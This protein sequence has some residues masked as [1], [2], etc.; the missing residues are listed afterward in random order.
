MVRLEHTIIVIMVTDQPALSRIVHTVIITVK[1]DTIT[2]TMV[3]DRHVCRVITEELDQMV[4]I[5]D[6]SRMAGRV[7][8]LIKVTETV[9]ETIHIAVKNLV[10]D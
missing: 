10:E 6:L 3:T 5:R 2:V 8:I 7:R 9:I 4:I 1:A